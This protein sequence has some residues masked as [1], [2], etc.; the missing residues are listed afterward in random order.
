MAD[1]RDNLFNSVAYNPTRGFLNELFDQY[2]NF[3]R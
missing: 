3:S 1:L 2:I